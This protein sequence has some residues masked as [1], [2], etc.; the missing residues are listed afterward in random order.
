MGIRKELYEWELLGREL[1][2]VNDYPNAGQEYSIFTGQYGTSIKEP[3]TCAE[4]EF[5]VIDRI[6]CKSGV[7]PNEYIVDGGTLTKW[8]PNMFIQVVINTTG[9]YRD[10]QNVYSAGISGMASPY[11]MTAY[12]LK[13]YDLWPPIYVTEGQT[14]DI[15]Y[16]LYNDLRQAYNNGLFTDIQEDLIL[17]QVFV[18]YTLYE[19]TDAVLAKKL[20]SLGVPVTVDS[21]MWLRQLMLKSKGMRMDT[22]EFYLKA[23][24]IIREKEKKKRI[25]QGVATVSDY[26]DG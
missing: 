16:T 4:D 23:K 20:V 2:V 1:F 24:K 6:S 19:G 5:Y 3:A 14:W 7:S 8:N 18:D 11:P 10:P 15:R 26:E 22:Y 12:R 17:A 9:Y 13:Y 21:V 25:M